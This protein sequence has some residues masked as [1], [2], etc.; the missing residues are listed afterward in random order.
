V[1]FD[2]VIAQ[3]RPKRIL[4]SAI[5]NER[6]PH[7]YLFN[8]PEGVGKEAMALEFAKALFCSVKE[9]A[10]CQNCSSCRRIDG[11]KHPDVMFLFPMP[12]NTSTEEQREIL[13]SLSR[14]RYFRTKPWANAQIGI[15]RIREIRHISTLKP[16]EGRRVFILADAEAMTAEAANALLKILE[17]PPTAMHLLL[18]T[19]RA[20]LL[21]PTILSRCQEVRFALLPEDEIAASLEK[22]RISSAE[23]E[24]LAVISGGSLQ[25][26]LRWHEGSIERG[27]EKVVE[28][29]RCTLRDDL[30]QFEFIE[31]MLK[32]GD[33]RQLRDVLD[34][35][36]IWFRD[37]LIYSRTGGTANSLANEDRRETLEKFI[38]AF[39]S[40]NYNRAMT[41]L[42]RAIEMMERN[43]QLNLILAVLLHQLGEILKLKGRAA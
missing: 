31:E 36:L 18:L 41:A 6:I 37:A 9:N 22:R 10:P 25:R 32:K 26:A 42:E 20:S 15:D 2:R 40:I 7:A 11:L 43:I 23:A 30:A 29:L 33:R 38:S 3:E 34:L 8:G 27:R 35:L 14:D 28:L 17:E 1:N 16:M 39:E 19:S 13:D 21:L 4:S 24:S 12:K 5:T